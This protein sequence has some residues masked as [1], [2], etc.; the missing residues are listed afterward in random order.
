MLQKSNLNEIHY[1]MQD[2]DTFGNQ[3]F[4]TLI[5]NYSCIE[6][7]RD[8]NFKAGVKFSECVFCSQFYLFSC[9]YFMF[10][11]FYGEN[12]VRYDIRI[13]FSDYLY[14]RRYTK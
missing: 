13:V 5:V 9:H 12:S 7:N 10:K 2:S 8:R 1:S 11:V 6:R 4:L 3:F 14:W